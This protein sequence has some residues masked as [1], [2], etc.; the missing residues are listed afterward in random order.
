MGLGLSY[1]FGSNVG[2]GLG[3]ELQG[4]PLITVLFEMAVSKVQ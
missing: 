3:L 4:I 2:A 1:V